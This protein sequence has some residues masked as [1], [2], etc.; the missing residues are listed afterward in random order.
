[1]S[2]ITDEAVFIE[3]LEALASSVKDHPNLEFDPDARKFRFYRGAMDDCQ[4]GVIRV[5][6]S[7]DNC[8]EIGI[9]EYPEGTIQTINGDQVDVSGKRYLAWDPYEYETSELKD[10]IGGNCNT[11]HQRYSYHA[12]NTVAKRINHRVVE[13]FNDKGEQQL[14]FHPIGGAVGGTKGGNWDKNSW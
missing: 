11:L 13:S 5:K 3:D 6:N 2:H 9:K 8:Y 14:A 7:A 1:M 12:L 10:A 4:H